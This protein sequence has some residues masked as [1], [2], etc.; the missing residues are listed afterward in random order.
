LPSYCRFRRRFGE[1]QQQV[2]Y[3][4]LLSLRLCCRLEFMPKRS[5]TNR[6]QKTTFLKSKIIEDTGLRRFQEKISRDY[7]EA[8][9]RQQVAALLPLPCFYGLMSE[10]V[11]A[12]KSKTGDQQM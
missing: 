7:E 9:N 1:K 10:K 2:A 4:L 5:A 12:S 11:A 3:L 6:Q 8:T